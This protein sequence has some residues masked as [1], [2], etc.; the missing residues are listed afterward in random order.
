[1]EHQSVVELV[2]ENKF[3]RPVVT[4]AIRFPTRLS[5]PK[6]GTNLFSVSTNIMPVYFGLSR[7][8]RMVALAAM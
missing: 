4:S 5:A 6:V 2:N 7:D 3:G 1:V 8:V